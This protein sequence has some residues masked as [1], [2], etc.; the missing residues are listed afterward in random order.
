[1]LIA[2]ASVVPATLDAAQTYVQA[3]LAGDA[4][5][6]EDV[7]FQASEWLFLGAL[8]P[9][10]YYLGQRYPL[11]RERWW[12]ALAVHLA[13]ALALCVG[14]ATLG[15]LLAALLQ[16]YP[17]MGDLPRDF[18]SWFLRSVPWS[19]FMY[20]TVLGCVYAFTYFVEARAQ[21]AQASRLAAQLAE[22]RLGALRMQ[23]NPHFLFNSLNAV[24]VL[25]RERNTAAATRMLELLGDLLRQALRQDQP[26]Q[27]PLAEE[28]SFLERYLAIEQV[29]FSDRLRVVW[30]IEERARAALVPGFVLQPIV[31][32]AV[33][34]GI[35]RRADAGRLEIAARVAG[36]R[37]ELAVRDDGVGMAP[38]QVEGVGLANTR[39]RLRTIYGNDA[40]LTIAARPG[41][42]TEAVLMLPLRSGGSGGSGG[43]GRSSGSGGSGGSGGA[44]DE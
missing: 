42:G 22:A 30:S 2:A 8:T 28:L 37:L 4:A 36:S 18:V 27:V 1:L 32:N 13:G 31:E 3:R 40:T 6:W 44:G 24:T 26:H 10:T 34:H 15:I 33:T 25:V 9:L 7:V 16:R 5:R 19:V 41:G 11:R 12:R 17:S 23:L 14:W 35:A 43:S 29:R 38:N 20:F 39:E 21:E